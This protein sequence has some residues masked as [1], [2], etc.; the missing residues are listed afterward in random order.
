MNIESRRRGLFEAKVEEVALSVLGIRVMW[1][2]VSWVSASLGCSLAIEGWA[3]ILH[4]DSVERNSVESAC[5]G[6]LERQLSL[7]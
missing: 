5:V 2:E 3:R 4:E 7:F 6:D 1:C